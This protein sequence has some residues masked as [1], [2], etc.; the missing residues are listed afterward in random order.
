MIT[1]CITEKNCVLTFCHINAESNCDQDEK[2]K[3]SI[4]VA[5]GKVRRLQVDCKRSG[6]GLEKIRQEKGSIK[7]SRLVYEANMPV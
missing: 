3:A 5:T 2:R 1:S 7:E 6:G 4:K